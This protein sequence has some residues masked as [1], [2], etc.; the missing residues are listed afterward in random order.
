VEARSTQT[1]SSLTPVG[2]TR[3]LVLEIGG[4]SPPTS[5]PAGCCQA[6]ACDEQE[7]MAKLGV[8]RTVIREAV[9]TLRAE[10]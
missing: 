5:P 7:L 8:S 3:S 6:S 1:L 10:G 4:E 2:R 9:A